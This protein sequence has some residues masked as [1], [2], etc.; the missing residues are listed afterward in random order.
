MLKAED[1]FNLKETPFVALFDGTQYVW[2][3]LK[4]IKSWLQHNIQPNISGLIANSPVL[5]KTVVLHDGRAHTQGCILEPG[6]ASKGAF[7][8][9]KDGQVL[10]GASV[11]YAGAI[12]M[13]ELIEIGPGAVVEP[14]ALIKGPAVIG[15]CA[16][17]RQGAYIRGD[18]LVGP[19]CV[20]G[21]ATEMKHA[22]MLGGSKAGHFAYIGDS[23]LGSV[24][25][26]AGTKLANVKINHDGVKLRIRD[27]V[28]DTGLRK[29]G[30]ICGDGVELGCNSVTSPGT[31]LGKNVLVYPNTNARGYHQSNTVVKLKQNQIIQQMRKDR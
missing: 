16:E 19:R 20:V 7:V 26:G 21:H 23:I 30:A 4:K 11:I 2:E 5:E 12:L 27:Q 6:D 9:R 24:N 29:F 15:C 3:G 10:E 17:V 14:G 31:L 18:V 28:Y 13:N 22:V 1:F 8:V 25:L